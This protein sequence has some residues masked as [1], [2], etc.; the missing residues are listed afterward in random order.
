[1]NSV[2]VGR[3]SLAPND[4]IAAIWQERQRYVREGRIKQPHPWRVALSE[5][6]VSR[7][8]IVE[9]VKNRYYFLANIN[10]KDAQVIANCPVPDARRRL[11]KKYIDEEGQDVVG[12]QLGPHYE[13]WIKISDALGIDP[14]VM[15]SF[16]DV[17]PV[18]RYTVDAVF[19]FAK[20]QSWLDGVAATYATE[21]RM[22][23]RYTPRSEHREE[24][25]LSEGEAMARH[26]GLPR[27]A[28]LFYH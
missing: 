17:L 7:R 14:Q 27:E 20:Q 19:H 26:Y 22:W 1:M 28:L 13:M 24:G 2:S 3:A 16:S 15:R 10:R 9:Y 11:L 25:L 5:G 6:K 21:G 4:L 8:A 12:G 23:K 18:Y